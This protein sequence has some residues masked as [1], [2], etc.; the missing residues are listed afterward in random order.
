MDWCKWLAGGVITIGLMTLTGAIWL[1]WIIL[2]NDRSSPFYG[3]GVMG[4]IMIFLLML[5]ASSVLITCGYDVWR[6]P[7]DKTI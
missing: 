6:G 7:G 5:V 1:M 4:G 2:A 3:E